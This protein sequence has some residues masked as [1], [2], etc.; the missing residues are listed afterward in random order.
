[1]LFMYR[2]PEK[3]IIPAQVGE[4]EEGAE[5]EVL[6][7]RNMIEIIIGKQIVI[8]NIVT[9]I[10]KERGTGQA[11]AI[12]IVEDQNEKARDVTTE[13]SLLHQVMVV[14]TSTEA[15]GER[16]ENVIDMIEDQALGLT[17]GRSLVRRTA[18][19]RPH[20]SITA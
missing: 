12:T 18:G 6:I 19:K 1:M 20:R 9:V 5:A 17:R 14:P 7:A 8:T 3:E 10:E 16:A 11:H 13:V 15:I 2:V 4:A